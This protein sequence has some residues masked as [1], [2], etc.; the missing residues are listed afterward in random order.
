[1][2]LW[3]TKRIA[4][5][6]GDPPTSAGVP[7][8]KR[9]LGAFDLTALGTGAMIGAGIFV[10]AGTAAAQMAGPAI[11]LSFVIAGVGCMFVGL[12]YAEL[13]S[14]IPAAGSAYTY[15]YASFG[16]LLA[17][18]VGWNLILEYLFG[19]ATVAVSWSAYFV[20]FLADWGVRLPVSL[21]QAPL[22]AELGWQIRRVPGATLNVPAMI[23]VLLMT[24]LLVVGIRASANLNNVIVVAKL[25]IVVAI[26]GFGF[27]YVSIS[28]WHPFIPP[29]GGSFGRFGWSGVVRGAGAVFFSFIGFDTVST[30]AQEARNPQRDLPIGILASIAISTTLYVLVAL[31][32][33]GL[34]PYRDLNAPHPVSVAVAAAGSGLHWLTYLVSVATVA[35]LASVVLVLLMGQSRILFAMSRDGL[36]PSVLGRMHSRFKTPYVT[37]ILTG[38]CA[39]A[40]AAFFPFGLLLD[41]VN[42]GALLAFVVVCCSILILRYRQPNIMRP[43]RTP[44]VPI[45]PVIGAL[46]SVGMLA[47]LPP[48]TWTRFAVWLVIGLVIYFLYGARKSELSRRSAVGIE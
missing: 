22:A 40:L 4:T 38:V 6:Q 36:V 16:E 45:V 23:M 21:T 11:A 18:I 12:C 28:N 2:G 33:T 29:S 41:V 19:A 3:S 30:A 26:I 34:V 17:W 44:W 14:M 37:T 25:A 8:F 42:V 32:M 24:A 43:F 5:L 1:M 47:T 48:E 7:A 39:S 20:A 31:V 15:S 13:A 10:L 46:F 9:V 27:A 35:G